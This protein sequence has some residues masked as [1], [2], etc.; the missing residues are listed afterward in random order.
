MESSGPK[1]K[2]QKNGIKNKIV[3]V[4]IKLRNAEVQYE[5]A[6]STKM[7]QEYWGIKARLLKELYALVNE[8]EGE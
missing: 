8:L 5:A 4:S 6:N 2:S 3:A 7:L 1:S